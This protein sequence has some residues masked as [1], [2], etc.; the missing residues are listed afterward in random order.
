MTPTE[1]C[2]DSVGVPAENQ[3]KKIKETTTLYDL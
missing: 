3:H 2:D 1:H